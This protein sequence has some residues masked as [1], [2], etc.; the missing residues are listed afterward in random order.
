ME[1]TISDITFL[2]ILQESDY[3]SVFLVTLQGKLYVLKV[4]LNHSPSII[5]LR[6]RMLIPLGGNFNLLFVRALRTLASKSIGY[7]NKE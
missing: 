5:P 6:D 7:A 1:F 4:V 2:H 3:S